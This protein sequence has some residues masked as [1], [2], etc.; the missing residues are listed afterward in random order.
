VRRA[1]AEDR[2]R[3]SERSAALGQIAAGVAHDMNNLVQSVVAAAR[4]LDRRAENP[5]E[6]RR[7]SGLV[8]D[9][10]ARG[11]RLARRMLEFG[12][13][14]PDGAERFDIAATLNGLEALL[15]GLLGSGLRLRCTA[16]ADLPE[17][18]ADRRELETVLVNLVVNA[19]DAM[20]DGGEVAVTAALD[21]SAGAALPGLRMRPGPMVRLS[22]A[23]TGTGMPP[24]VLARA[25]EPFFSTKPTGKGTGLGLTMARQFAE[26]AG[27][28]MRIESAPGRGTTIILWLP[29]AGV[30]PA[31]SAGV[32]AE[33][34]QA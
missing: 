10:A 34:D 13:A 20:P 1:E 22:V 9:A 30:A 7:L 16:P 6:V 5:S 14:A 15:G 19:R 25:E 2:L 21:P 8:R 27:G 31:P 17:V 12:R 23:D 4:L 11:A 26:R 3:R 32:P 24:E 33:A 18:E 28:A 29:A